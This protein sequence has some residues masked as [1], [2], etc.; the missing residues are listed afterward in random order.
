MCLSVAQPA[1]RQGKHGG[2]G[3]TKFVGRPGHILLL[4][5]S[6]TTKGRTDCVNCTLWSDC[7]SQV[8]MVRQG[9]TYM[10][11]IIL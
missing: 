5:G 11:A 8:C 10:C 4:R 1:A 9:I 7:S 3:R 6:P 2:Q